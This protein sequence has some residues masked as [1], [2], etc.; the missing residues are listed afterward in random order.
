ME[1]WGSFR[2]CII[3]ARALPER[4]GRMLLVGVSHSWSRFVR[5]H[6]RKTNSKK[7][8]DILTMKLK[9]PPRNLKL[10]ISRQVVQ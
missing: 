5:S 10:L 7:K 6:S 9:L 8:L 1:F 3:N 4:Q 2:W